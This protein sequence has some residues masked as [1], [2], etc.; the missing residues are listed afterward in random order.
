MKWIQPW[1]Q[2]QKN[3]S[4]CQKGENKRTRGLMTPPRLWHPSQIIPDAVVNRTEIQLVIISLF[5]VYNLLHSKCLNVGSPE[6]Q[7]ERERDCESNVGSQKPSVM[8][9]PPD[10]LFF[11]YWWTRQLLWEPFASYL[12][13]AGGYLASQAANCA[14]CRLYYIISALNT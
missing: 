10:R 6:C 14:R 8:I 7:R 2:F 3:T 12:L 1:V 4:S 13:L 11:I 5:L 9:I